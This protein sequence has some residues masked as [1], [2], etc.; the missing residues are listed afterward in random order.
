MPRS[1]NGLYLLVEHVHIHQRTKDLQQA[2]LTTM[3]EVGLQTSRDTPSR[4]SLV[5]EDAWLNMSPIWQNLMHFYYKAAQQPLPLPM[6]HF[7]KGFLFPR[8]LNLVIL[9]MLG[10]WAASKIIYVSPVGGPKHA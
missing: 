4:W 9:F 6:S 5:F 1:D 2:V 10:R 7:V 8:K 3:R